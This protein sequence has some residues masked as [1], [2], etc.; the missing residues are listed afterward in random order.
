MAAE[1]AT[2]AITRMARLLEVSTSG[3]YKRVK[4]SATTELSDRE[5]RKADLTVKIID[6]HRESA[7]VY[8]SPRITADL[9]AAGEVVSEK[10][11]AKIMAEIGLVGIS[12]RTFKVRTTIV[13]P[14]ASF[15]ADLVKRQFDQGRCDAVWSSDIT[16]LTCGEGDMYLCAL[17]DEH[18]KRVLGWSV[19]D[20]MLTELVT[21]ALAQAVAVRDGNVRGTIM[22]S[23]RGAQFTAQAM[24]RACAEA[25]LR[26]SMGATGICW[27]NS[28]AE[29]L[30]STFKHEYYYRHVFGTKTELVAAVDKWMNYYNNQRRHSAIGML[31]PISYEQSLNAAS[32]AA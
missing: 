3:F 8:G 25:G 19:A 12:P 21:D 23:D 6:H 24:A 14:T 10:T 32:Q 26:R 16:H 29:S 1:C 20:H 7:G 18:S 13:D 4:R 9:R 31:S 27:D 5:Q 22:H 2:T 17:R 30:W 11:V 15:P 28:G